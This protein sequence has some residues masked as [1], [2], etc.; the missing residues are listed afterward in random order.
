[1]ENETGRISV[2]LRNVDTTAASRL[3]GI[4]RRKNTSATDQRV[5]IEPRSRRVAA[6]MSRDK[7]PTWSI[8]NMIFSGTMPRRTV[9]TCSLGE[10]NSVGLLF[11]CFTTDDKMIGRTIAAALAIAFSFSPSLAQPQHRLPSGYKWGRCLLV[12]SGQTRISGRCSYQIETG[13]D[14]NIQG[15]RQVFAGIDYPDAHSGADEMSEDYWAVVYK[16]GDVWDGYG[17]SDIPETHGEGWGELRR[18]GACYVGK[19]VRVCLWR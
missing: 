3:A 2:S 15:P 13:G 14:F 11:G 4:T 5:S 16:E 18:E 19:D 7:N 8:N 1:M 12:V 10:S 17:N 9:S 6:Q